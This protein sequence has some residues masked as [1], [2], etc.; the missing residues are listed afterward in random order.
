M[1]G[2]SSNKLN[3]G[4][5]GYQ[6]LVT[7]NQ[8]PL[9]YSSLDIDIEDDAKEEEEADETPFNIMS[10]KSTIIGSKRTLLWVMIA[11]LFVLLCSFKAGEAN[12]GRASVLKAS[13]GTCKPCT[14]LQVSFR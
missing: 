5:A 14:F 13:S 4:S 12:A 3:S 2:V 11:S 9:Q 8:Q 6:P 7:G 10:I 1:E